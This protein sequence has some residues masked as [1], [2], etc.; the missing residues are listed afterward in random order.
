M[1]WKMTHF[2]VKG[3]TN[4]TL[5]LFCQDIFNQIVTVVYNVNI[6]VIYSKRVGKVG[7]LSS[8]LSR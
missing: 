4:G 7:M 6:L 2:V 5:E 8:S 1:L 3:L